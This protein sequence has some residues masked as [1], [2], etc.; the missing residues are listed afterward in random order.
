[1]IIFDWN[2]QGVNIMQFY[3]VK[4]PLSQSHW[5]AKVPLKI[6]IAPQADPGVS[7]TFP[8]VPYDGDKSWLSILIISLS[9][10]IH[11]EGY[12]HGLTLKF[13]LE[14]YP[15]FMLF[16]LNGRKFLENP[17][18]YRSAVV[19]SRIFQKSMFIAFFGSQR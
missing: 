8:K 17:C 4:H 9:P 12:K 2:V 3:R 7:W 18:L 16:Q 10:G 6:S 13:T 19:V 1:M 11:G 5:L 14:L 15:Y